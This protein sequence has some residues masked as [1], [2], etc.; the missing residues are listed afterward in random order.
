[1]SS[2]EARGVCG[3]EAAEELGGLM[4]HRFVRTGQADVMGG[5]L[6]ATGVLH[7]QVV[8]SGM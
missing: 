6:P 5:Q 7:E 1:M 8:C 4:D 2:R 3:E